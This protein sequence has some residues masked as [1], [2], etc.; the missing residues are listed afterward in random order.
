MTST[1]FFVLKLKFLMNILLVL[2]VHHFHYEQ[3]VYVEGFFPQRTTCIETTN[4]EAM[5]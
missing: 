5:S 1:N 3:M 4:G 2:F